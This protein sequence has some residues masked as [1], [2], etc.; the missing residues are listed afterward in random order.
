MEKGKGKDIA[1]VMSKIDQILA[2]NLRQNDQ[3]N[4]IE[5]LITGNGNPDNGIIVKTTKLTSK[6]DN[7]CA[8][9]K[10]HRGLLV[11]IAGSL[12]GISM[13]VIFGT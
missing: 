6:V 12:I 1:I 5:V 2:D 3:L 8:A 9:L 10:I 4:K 13:K 11:T 7:L